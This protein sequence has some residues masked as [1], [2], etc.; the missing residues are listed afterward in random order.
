M[1]S[2]EFRFD[3]LLLAAGSFIVIDWIVEKRSSAVKIWMHLYKTVNGWN[4]THR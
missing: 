2:A 4:Q 3:T 1:A